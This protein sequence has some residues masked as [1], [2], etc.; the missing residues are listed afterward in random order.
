MSGSL[1][2]CFSYGHNP[3]PTFSISAADE[4]DGRRRLLQ[5]AQSQVEMQ[6]KAAQAVAV[7]NTP[8]ASMIAGEIDRQTNLLSRAVRDFSPSWAGVDSFMASMGERLCVSLDEIRWQSAQLANS[9]EAILNMVDSKRCKDARDLVGQGVRHYVN[10]EFKEAE[11]RFLKVLDFD[12]TDY[13]V[14]LNL[15]FIE[16]HKG[17]AD[18]AGAYFHKAQKLPEKL[19]DEARARVLSILARLEYARKNFS[20][21]AS[22]AR[23]A[24]DI[25]RLPGDEYQAAVY[26]ALAG[27][28]DAALE[29][30]EK[31]VK[32]DA[33]FFAKA[34]VDP[35]LQDEQKTVLG[36]FSRLSA[37]VESSL[38]A[39]FRSC[40]ETFLSL[41]PDRGSRLGVEVKN[42]VEQILVETREILK[43]GSYSE[44]RELSKIMPLLVDL[45]GETRDFEGDQQDVE[46]QKK[47]LA[48]ERIEIDQKIEE[49]QGPGKHKDIEQPNGCGVSVASYVLVFILAWI[50]VDKIGFGRSFANIHETAFYLILFFSP[51]AIGFAIVPLSIV[52]TNRRRKKAYEE[53]QKSR[54]SLMWD[55]GSNKKKMDVLSSENGK[56][57]N[58]LV[59]KRHVFQK[60]LKSLKAG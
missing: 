45:A 40:E 6:R 27:D 18:Q 51:L 25:R 1:M 10:F 13:Q 53:W 22:L 5:F 9:P 32:G 8:G 44:A 19:T 20:E 2:D 16:L 4:E 41:D 49:L 31:L 28:W 54:D 15:G 56:R 7:S 38:S 57:F 58:S 50:L 17:D 23:Q 26:A 47:A 11:E 24:R 35:D 30:L 36:L 34:A 39:Q 55:S 48:E 46:A 52:L 3:W 37:G 12:T 60:K 59:D 42:H 21:A 43:G 29:S 14:L 33:L